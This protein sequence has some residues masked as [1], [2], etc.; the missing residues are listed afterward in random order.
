MLYALLFSHLEHY[1]VEF[2][3]LEHHQQIVLHH[4]G[5]EKGKCTGRLQGG[6]GKRK[7]LAVC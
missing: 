3:V 7:L 1:V 5:G 2:L 6:N 4:L